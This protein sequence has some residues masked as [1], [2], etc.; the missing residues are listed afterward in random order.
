M[1]KFSTYSH[2]VLLDSSFLWLSIKHSCAFWLCLGIAT[3]VATCV[4][5]DV[6]VVSLLQ[7]YL[8]FKAHCSSGLF[9]WQTS[10]LST[11]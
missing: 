7:E 11:D 5:M 1:N 9:C 2:C 10:S 3:F 4:F 6:F 8:V